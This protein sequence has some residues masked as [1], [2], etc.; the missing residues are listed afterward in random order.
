MISPSTSRPLTIR[1]TKATGPQLKFWASRARWRLFV[2]GVG[3]G[4]TRAGCVEILRQPAGSTGMVLAPTYPMLRDATLRTFL[5]LARGA[6]V[7]ASFNKGEMVA[8]LHGNRTV[9]F[10]SADNPD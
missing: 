3:S 9:L 4:K 8:R 10:R 5:D 1:H 6:G 7:L 2:G